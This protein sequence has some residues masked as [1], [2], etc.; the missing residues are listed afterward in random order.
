[1]AIVLK[2]TSNMLLNPRIQVTFLDE[3]DRIIGAKDQSIVAMS[4]GGKA[5]MV[6]YN[7]EPFDSCE[8]KLTATE[9]NYYNDCVSY[10]K[11]DVSFAKDKAIIQVTNNG[12]KPAEFVE[13]IALSKHNGQVVYCDIG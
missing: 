11:T 1:M 5:A 7:E 2:N 12:N 9:E 4:P 13:Y 6:F 8:Y 3:N 10:L